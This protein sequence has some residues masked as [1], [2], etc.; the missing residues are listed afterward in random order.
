MSLQGW[1]N[2]SFDP[3]RD[4]KIAIHGFQD[5]RLLRYWLE[6]QNIL[7]DMVNKGGPSKPVDEVG[8]GGGGGVRTRSC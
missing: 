5:S 4:T 6:M 7:L 3:E 1:R 8:R 2:C